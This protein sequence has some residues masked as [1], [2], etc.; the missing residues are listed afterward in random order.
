[1]TFKVHFFHFFNNL[2]VSAPDGRVYYYNASIQQST[3]ERPQALKELDEARM[4][5]HRTSLPPPQ[6]LQQQQAPITQGNITFDSAGNMVN[7]AAKAKLDAEKEKK[8]REEAEKAKQA[9]K[10]LDKSRPISSTPISG[11]PWCVVW[12]GDNKVFFYNPST[13][14]SVWTRPE[15][16]VGKLN[17]TYENQT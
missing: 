14:T 11:T 2:F 5:V 7:A 3:W 16:L 15:D 17:L 13:R 6:Q 12:T 4:A 10:P 8:R 9:A 1:L